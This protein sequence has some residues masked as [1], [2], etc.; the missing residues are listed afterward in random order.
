M[1][2]ISLILP[3]VLLFSCVDNTGGNHGLGEISKEVAGAAFT[4]TGD[5]E[6]TS[7]PPTSTVKNEE[8]NEPADTVAPE[9]TQPIVYSTKEELVLLMRNTLTD[10]RA[11]VTQSTDD[12]AYLREVMSAADGA[13][14]IREIRPYSG[15]GYYKLGCVKPRGTLGVFSIVEL[16]FSDGDIDIWRLPISGNNIPIHGSVALEISEVMRSASTVEELTQAVA[17]LDKTKT[18]TEVKVMSSAMA[19]A[20]EVTSGQIELLARITVTYKDGAEE[21]TITFDRSGKDWYDPDYADASAALGD[22]VE[23]AVPTCETIEELVARIKA[24]ESDFFTVT[25]VWVSRN[26]TKLEGGPLH[27]G[28][29]IMVERSDGFQTIIP[30]SINK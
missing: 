1:C 28:D 5:D 25:G 17:E 10:I 29:Y 16:E 15:Y 18:V 8:S 12:I 13:E 6:S 2:I 21:L 27:S 14:L 11:R 26:G 22:A 4:S 23:S 30:I 7:A 20:V 19:D 3:A 9:E 24:Y